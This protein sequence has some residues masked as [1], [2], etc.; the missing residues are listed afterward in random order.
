LAWIPRWLIVLLV[1][2]LIIFLMNALGIIHIH[3]NVG[4]SISL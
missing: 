4:G 2:A 1:I 3:G